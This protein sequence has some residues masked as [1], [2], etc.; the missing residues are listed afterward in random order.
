MFPK[1]SGSAVLKRCSYDSSLTA[2]LTRAPW[3]LTVLFRKNPR[4]SIEFLGFRMC[5]GRMSD[6]CRWIW[7][8]I[9]IFGE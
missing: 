9:F 2:G 3:H 6:E 8:M 1:I 4:S 5:L 7:G